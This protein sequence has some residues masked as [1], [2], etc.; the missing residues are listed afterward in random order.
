M[1]I[2]FKRVA[3]L[4]LCLCMAAVP[5][6]ACAGASSSTPAPSTPT[7]TSA[8]EAAPATNWPTKGISIVCPFKAGGGMDLST[9]LTAKYL[10][11]YLG[12]T[13]TVNNVEGGNSWTG[14]TQVAQANPDGYTLGFANYPAQVAGYLNPSAGITLTYKDFTSIANVV[15]DANILVVSAKHSPYTTM[16]ELIEYAKENDIVLGTGGGAG[17]DDDVTI[18][19]INDGLGTKIESG[20]NASTAESKA[21]ML[22]G[23]IDG[24]IANVSEYYGLIDSTGDDAI[25]I[26]AVFAKERSDFIPDVPT[27]AECG[28]PDIFGGSDRGLIGPPNLDPQVKTILIDTLKEIQNDP[29]F[30]ADAKT[31]GLGIGMIFGEDFDAYIGEM[32]TTMVEMKPLFGWS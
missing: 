30:L 19:K 28:Y 6:S 12:V 22:G 26:L 29:D 11:K 2:K 32:E 25:R 7:Q 4:A 1:K 10:E 20:R 24:V 9:R 17:S 14:W 13:V 15:A 18:A 3:A 31:Q 21:A 27:A 8:P 16:A 23:H 5:L